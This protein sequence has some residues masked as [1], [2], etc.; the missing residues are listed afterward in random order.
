MFI[1]KKKI[2]DYL[3]PSPAIAVT[4]I[5]PSPSGLKS[6][7]SPRM[8]LSELSRIIGDCVPETN[9]TKELRAPF[10]NL[11][12]GFKMTGDNLTL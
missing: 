1:K 10:N 11:S 8:D 9:A 3:S 5:I 6:S 7:R 2:S 12:L 4:P